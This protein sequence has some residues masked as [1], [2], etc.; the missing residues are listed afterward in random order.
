MNNWGKKGIESYI[1][2]FLITAVVISSLLYFL[3][4]KFYKEDP[5]ECQYYDYEIV[6][7]CEQSDGITLNIN[8][9]GNKELNL[10]IAGDIKDKYTISPSGGK[11]FDIFTDSKS[12]EVLPVVEV[13]G[14]QR[15]CR[16]H[17]KTINIL[18]L[19]KC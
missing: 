10:K 7:K 2:I 3:V 13:S 16:S 12:V 11:K 9:K 5:Q 1:F 15:V 18:R 17:K 6:Q 4:G 8:N 19:G 14:E